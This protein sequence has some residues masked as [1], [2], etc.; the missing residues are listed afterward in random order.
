MDF[1]P[2]T[3]I[4]SVLARSGVRY[5]GAPPTGEEALQWI[6]FPKTGLYIFCQDLFKDDREVIVFVTHGDIHHVVKSED[7]ALPL[8]RAQNIKYVLGVRRDVF[9]A[10][11]GKLLLPKLAPVS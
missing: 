6:G 11:K 8:W 7:E 3:L 2:H 1:S 5:L 10:H 4:G 9:E